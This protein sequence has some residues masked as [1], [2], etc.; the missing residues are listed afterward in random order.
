MSRRDN[1]SSYNTY[2]REPE[3]VVT[4]VIRHQPENEVKEVTVNKKIITETIEIDDDGIYA[5]KED[6]LKREYEHLQQ[7]LAQKEKMLT[8][9]T[10]TTH[11]T[12]HT[13]IHKE[14]TELKMKLSEK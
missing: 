12:T 4:R 11:T 7:L 3:R 1:Y 2:F 5:E 9:H 6:K 8:S 14:I 10:T 13:T